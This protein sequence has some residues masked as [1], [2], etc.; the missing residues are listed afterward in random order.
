MAQ[1]GELSE[2]QSVHCAR[3]PEQNQPPCMP[4]SKQHTSSQRGATQYVRVYTDSLSLVACTSGAT[5]SEIL[6]RDEITC[7][8]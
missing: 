2:W 5:Y 8:N 4:V 1:L 6:L 7:C 3:T